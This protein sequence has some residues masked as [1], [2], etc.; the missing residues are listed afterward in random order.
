MSEKMTMALFNGCVL[1]ILLFTQILIIKMSRKDI[2]LGIKI[3]ED[4]MKTGEVKEII[5]GYTR[6]NLIIGIPALI[7]ISLLIYYIDNIYLFSSSIFIYIGI[8]FLVY[9]R[10]N[11]K[12]KELKK[13][14]KWDKLSSKTIVID[15]KFSRDKGITNI[16]SRR[17]FLIPLGIVALSA[18]LSIIMYP[19]LPDIVPTHW[20]IKGNVDGWMNKSIMVATMMPLMQ[21]IM[22]IIMYVSN[23][24]IIISKQQI[25][26][27][28]PE[29]SLK[30]NILFRKAWSIYL[31]VTLIILEIFFT[32][33]NMVTLGI[34]SNMKLINNLN[35]ATTGLIV[36]GAIVLSVKIGQGGD[37]LKLKDEEVS[38][39]YDIDDD[40]LWKLGNTI[41][42]N[43]DDSS[44][45]IEKRVGSGWTVNAGRPSGMAI[46]I[47]P[48]IILIITFLFV[49]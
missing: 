26:S 13:A 46:L 27:K 5:K 6:E 38:Q 20:D 11:K 4:K 8:L 33:M 25:D 7:I 30:R 42:Y 24:F 17:W 35:L 2:L 22:V 23:H 49:K 18:V 45:F 10:W 14:M 37:K 12:T 16:I 43:K 40:D 3:P 36:L 31:I 29:E 39:D 21:L 19:S 32:L 41:Y 28:N 9:L 47:A 1:L 34:L 48:F 15:T 44:L